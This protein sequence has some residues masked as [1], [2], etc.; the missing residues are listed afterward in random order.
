M[1]QVAQSFTFIRDYMNNVF[2]I[3][4]EIHI[5]SRA[6]PRSLQYWKY[7][8]DICKNVF[9]IVRVGL[10]DLT[11]NRTKRMHLARN[12]FGR[13]ASTLYHKFNC[14]ARF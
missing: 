4:L 11:T 12:A 9:Q 10:M 3:R 6:P 5:V 13:L 8:A 2:S 1:N 7:H 14:K